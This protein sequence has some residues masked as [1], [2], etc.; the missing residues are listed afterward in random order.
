MI[1]KKKPTPLQSKHFAKGVVKIKPRK[2]KELLDS[3]Y[4]RIR[5]RNKMFIRLESIKQNLSIAK[6]VDK[7]IESYK[8]THDRKK[9]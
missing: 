7:I 8:D 1:A 9:K 3:L 4:V 2:T 5:E 6:T